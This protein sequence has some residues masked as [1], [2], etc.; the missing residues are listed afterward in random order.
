ML[1]P[2]AYIGSICGIVGNNAGLGRIRSKELQAAASVLG[3]QG[4][5]RVVNDPK[6][7]DQMAEVFQRSASYRQR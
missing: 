7:Q 3:I 2:M 4:V 5:V 1:N 6:M